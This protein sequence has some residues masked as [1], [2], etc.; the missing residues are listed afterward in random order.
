MKG[1]STLT[2]GNLGL[3]L[4]NLL[5]YPILTRLYN[6]GD[7]G[8]LSKFVV[9]STILSMLA[10]GQLHL[11]LFK[12]SEDNLTLKANF[13]I[14]SSLG[15][16]SA[17]TFFA[18]I[19]DTFLVLVGVGAFFFLL[20]EVAKVYFNRQRFYMKTVSLNATSRIIGQGGRVISGSYF[21][22]GYGL[23]VFEIVGN[24]VSSLYFL[25]NLKIKIPRQIPDSLGKEVRYYLPLGLMSFL[26]EEWALLVLIKVFPIDLLGQFFLFS[27]LVLRPVTIIGNNFSSAV[28]NGLNDEN[29]HPIFIKLITALIF[30]AIPGVITLFFFGEAMFSF[31]LGVAYS[32]VGV[33]S[34]YLG[35]LI[36]VKLLKGLIT[37]RTAQ[38]D[39]YSKVLSVR[40]LTLL[41]YAIVT[42]LC[43]DDLIRML[44]L[45]GVVEVMGECLLL[46]QLFKKSER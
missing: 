4:L 1:F 5:I 3:I 11:S 9:Y 8:D 27:R 39:Q 2:L 44:V 15:A 30:V 12:D 24:I 16:L 22:I 37:I 35:F 19:Y 17:F 13:I 26:I 45:L 25:K 28:I 34:S 7:F 43:K 29:K 33:Y 31:I 46:F 38:S 6:P 18:A 42:Y 36:I 41:G 20:N 10:S 23:I 32:Q 21:S 40:G 14:F